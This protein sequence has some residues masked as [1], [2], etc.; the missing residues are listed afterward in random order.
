MN[1]SSSPRP[2]GTGPLAAADRATLEARLRAEQARLRA[3]IAQR[4]RGQ[5]DPQAAGLA[6]RPPETGDDWAAADTLAEQDVAL[7]SRELAELRQ[8]EQALDRLA[9]GR[10]GA[11]MTCSR[12]IPLPRLLAYPSATRCV[13]CQSAQE[14]AGRAD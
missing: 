3:E 5:D 13:A 12:P 10:Y 2:A 11:C 4:L 6:S 9:E 8:V 1:A 14:K 7:V